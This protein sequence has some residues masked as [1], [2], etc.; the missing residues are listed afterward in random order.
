M[1]LRQLSC[2]IVVAE[3]LNFRRAAE[4]L[5]ISQP[6]V[7]RMI[8]A[9]E[10]DLGAPLFTRTR[11]RISLAPAGQ[12]LLGGARDILARARAAKMQAQ[13]AAAGEVGILELAFVS[14]AGVVLMPALVRA[15]RTQFPDVSLSLTAMTTLEQLQ[16][17]REDRIQIGL[18]RIITDEPGL[19]RRIVC[20]E[21]L[22]AIVPDGH[23][24]AEQPSIRIRDLR[25]EPLIVYPRADGPVVYDRIIDHCRYAGFEPSIVQECGHNQ[26]MTGLVAAEVGIALAIGTPLSLAGNGVR[27]LNLTDDIPSWPLSLAWRVGRQSATATAFLNVADGMRFEGDAPMVVPQ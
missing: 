10:E 21:R 12:E 19:E 8:Q 18:L 23:P 25:D 1:E 5:H 26:G 15:F 9:L 17:L 20:E 13:R 14:T 4:R 7:T 22:Y 27:V 2:F 6:H 16:A 3:E 11:R 24:R